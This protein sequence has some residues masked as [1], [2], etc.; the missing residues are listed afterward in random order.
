MESY[1]L[2]DG[3]NEH[4]EDI[5]LRPSWEHKTSELRFLAAAEDEEHPLVKVLSTTNFTKDGDAYTFHYPFEFAGLPWRVFAWRV[6]TENGSVDYT[7]GRV[8]VE[9]ILTKI[10]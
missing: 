6:T 7:E 10:S 8:P 9:A 5:V 3:F 4:G 2:I 1:N